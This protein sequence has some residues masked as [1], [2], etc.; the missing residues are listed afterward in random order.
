MKATKVYVT[1]LG[2]I[3]ALGTSLEENFRAL[4][5]A[6]SGIDHIRYLPT[7]QRGVLPVGEV[8]CSEGE[9]LERLP[10]RRSLQTA[11]THLLNLLALREALTHAGLCDSEEVK[12][13]HLLGLATGTS[14]GGMD[15]SENFYAQ[16]LKDARKGR[17]R[18]IIHHDPGAIAD[19][20]A[21][22]L[23]IRGF[24]T[25]I[26]TACSSAANAI[27]LG[28][29]LIRQGRLERV[30]AGGADALTRFTLNGFNSLMILDEQPCRPFDATRKGLNLGEGAAYLVLESAR[31]V[32]ARRA[33]V[34]CELSGYG[35]AND[36]HHQTASSPEGTGARLAMQKAM[37]VSGLTP[38]DISYINAHGTG[39]L[40]NDVSEGMALQTLFDGEVPPLSS[41]KAYTGHTLA[42]AGGLEAVFSVL[43]IQHQCIWPNLRFAQPMPEL[44]FTPQTQLRKDLPVRHVLSNSFGFGGNCTSLVFSAVQD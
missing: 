25:T 2:I 17:L 11:R 20:A 41:T 30:V 13:G 27:M 10:P 12:E 38:T 18:D 6:R 29:R 3:S 37:K 31:S 34:L 16:Y 40:N 39:T 43:A 19:L 24:V 42:A 26:S 28:A 23:G 32:E 8:K 33:E 1:G 9:L 7:H 35:N 36:A 5:S 44:D 21:L 4:C 22:E 14:V 15:K